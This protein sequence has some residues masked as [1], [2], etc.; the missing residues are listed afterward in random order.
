MKFIFVAILLALF[1]FGCHNKNK[2]DI[3]ST[4]KI[5][6]I[7]IK[8][9][10]TVLD[11]EI[12]AKIQAIK[13]VEIRSRI[14]GFLENIL[15]DEGK[16][17]KKGQPLFKLSSPEYTAEFTKAGAMLR[18]SIA[19]EVAANL[20]IDRVK[21]LVTK[22]VV[23]TTELVLVESKAQVAKAAVAESQAS[24]K[25][26]EAFLAYTTIIA[27]YDGIIN[28]IPLKI[29]S[30]INEGDLLTSIS[31]ISSIYVYFY[32][33]EIE[34]L[35]YLKAKHDRDSIQGKQ[36]VRL[37][38]ADGSFYKYD[39]IIETV[40]SE[41][42]GMTGA[43]AFRARFANS[44]HLLKHGASG[45]IRLETIVENVIIIPQRSV[46]EIQDKNYVFV[47][48][49]N[50]FVKLRN[51]ELGRRIGM[52]YL[53]KSGLEMNEK[54]VFEGVQVLRDGTKITPIEKQN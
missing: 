1:A 33:P 11:N 38:L 14:K 23:A 2:I 16:E 9:S 43:I 13:N 37:Q 5:P 22:N 50:S 19:E 25:N 42:D 17:V 3:T 41:I 46:L 26:A 44:E 52:S 53:V 12:V 20:E 51:I 45:T 6:V 30:L 8:L 29:G 36:K 28:R 39:G 47:V 49:Q 40:A 34:Y 18:R 31:D 10:N 27:P 35:K 4:P 48:D 15:V 54:I 24:F 21:L 7:T 32:L